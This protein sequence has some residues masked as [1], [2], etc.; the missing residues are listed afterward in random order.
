MIPMYPSE[1][2]KITFKLVDFKGNSIYFANDNEHF[3]GTLLI[4][5]D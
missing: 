5:N 2:Y 4:K 1:V 3:S